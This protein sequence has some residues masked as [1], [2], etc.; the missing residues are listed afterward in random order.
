V[1]Y[2]ACAAHTLLASVWDV[3]TSRLRRIAETLAW[4]RVQVLGFRAEG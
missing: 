1:C 4:F 3:E 2:L